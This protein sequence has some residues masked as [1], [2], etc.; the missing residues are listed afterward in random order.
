MKEH[1]SLKYWANRIWLVVCLLMLLPAV[2]L[3]GGCASIHDDRWDIPPSKENRELDK[4]NT[5]LEGLVPERVWSVYRHM[6]DEVPI[7][8]PPLMVLE[9][10][11][12]LMIWEQKLV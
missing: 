6:D 3:I 1:F 11:P 4:K 9:V 5:S 12:E 10:D 7:I 2:N 8:S